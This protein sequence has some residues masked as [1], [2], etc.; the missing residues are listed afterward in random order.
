MRCLVTGGAGFIGS[1]LVRHLLERGDEVRVLDNLST[2]K[3]DNLLGTEAGLL[4]GDLRDPVDVE[5]AVRGVER[6]F[7]LAALA[8]VARSVRDPLTTHAVNATGTLMLLDACRQAGVKRLVY[9]SSSSVYGNSPAQPKEEGMKPAPASPYAVSKLAGEHYCRVFH[10]TYGLETV[11]LRYFNVFGPRQ[12][13]DSE[14]AAVIPRFVAA[15]SEGSSPTL[16]GDGTQSRDFT[17]VANV[18]DAIA[19]AAEAEAAAGEVLNI[20]CGERR[21]LLDLLSELGE[22]DGHPVT[23]RFEAPRAGDIKHSQADISRARRVLGYRPRIGFHRGLEE[24]VAW[25]QAAHPRERT[26]PMLQKKRDLV[27]PGRS[28]SG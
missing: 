6:V 5:A 9:S 21:S 12:D 14:Y 3:R 20:A 22:I 18:V 28:L 11:S 25:F 4:E 27:R 15:A 7:H 8:S 23:P 13:P 24:T 17:Y 2:G 19:A 1:H 26:Q 16:Y 10:E